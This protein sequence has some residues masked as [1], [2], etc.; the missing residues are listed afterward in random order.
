MEMT[1]ETD[2]FM[3]KTSA[4]VS[5]SPNSLSMCTSCNLF[6]TSDADSRRHYSGAA[7]SVIT[8]RDRRK[9][10]KEKITTR[11]AEPNAGLEACGR[12]PEA[13]RLY[14]TRYTAADGFQ[15]EANGLT[16]PLH[17]RLQV[18]DP[19]IIPGPQ[20]NLGAKTWGRGCE[21]NDGFTLWLQNL[22]S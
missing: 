6:M 7:Q 2:I 19:N 18:P 9:G 4:R 12:W 21:M 5:N 15:K 1:L 10:R 11:A 3:I 20:L 22:Y 17:R 13:A 8:G 14:A 16:N